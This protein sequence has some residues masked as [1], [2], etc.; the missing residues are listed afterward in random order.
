MTVPSIPAAEAV[1][2]DIPDNVG[3]LARPNIRL[4]AFIAIYNFRLEQLHEERKSHKS[5]DTRLE[6]A[7]KILPTIATPYFHQGRIDRFGVLACDGKGMFPPTSIC[8]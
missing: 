2:L 8:K 7:L 5:S 6:K 4:A 1:H 3:M